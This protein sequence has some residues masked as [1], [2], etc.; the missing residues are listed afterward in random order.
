MSSI[1][2]PA[3]P[4]DKPE[5]VPSPPLGWTPWLRE[6]PDN[7]RHFS[8]DPPSFRL[9]AHLITHLPKILVA[10]AFLVGAAVKS[11]Q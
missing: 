4:S 2:Q 10:L 3:E 6:A 7:L 9:A 11:W 1:K 5:V 8:G